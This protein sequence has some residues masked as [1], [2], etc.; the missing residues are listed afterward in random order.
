MTKIQPWEQREDESVPAFEAFKHYRDAGD[1][2]S[3][4]KTAD[5]LGKSRQLI[6]RWASQYSWAERMRAYNRQMDRDARADRRRAYNEM[7]MTHTRVAQ[8][9][10]G[11]G[12]AALQQVDA[13][14]LSAGDAIRSIKLGIEIEREARGYNIHQVVTPLEDVAQSTAERI[15]DLNRKSGSAGPNLG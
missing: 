13:S 7:Y 6:E 15:A 5:A 2:R 11:R 14:A 9:L 12:L 10:I 1:L 3:Y 4:S 8:V